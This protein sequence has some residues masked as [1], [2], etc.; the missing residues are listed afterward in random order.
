MKSKKKVKKY[1]KETNTFL[2]ERQENTMEENE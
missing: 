2:K 1:L